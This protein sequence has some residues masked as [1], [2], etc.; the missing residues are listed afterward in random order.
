[1]KRDKPISLVGV[2]VQEA[3]SFRDCRPEYVSSNIQR[4]EIDR[5]SEPESCEKP[6]SDTTELTCRG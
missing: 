5:A 6:S 4:Y 2:R 1:M 3:E